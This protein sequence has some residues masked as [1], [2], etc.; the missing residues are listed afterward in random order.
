[1]L[2]GFLKDW[3]FWCSDILESHISY[4][5][6]G[7]FR[8][9]HTKQ[10][11]VSALACVLDLSSLIEV[12]IDGVP[13]WQAHVTF[14]MARHTAV[15]L[16]QVFRAPIADGDER[17]VDADFERMRNQLAAVGVCLADTPAAR[18]RL[19]T[20]RRS[21]EPYLVGLSRTL[22]MPLPPW[23]KERP[24]KDN[25]QSSPGGIEEAHF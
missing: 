25:W 23:W 10:S 18:D 7:F 22:L 24:E 11:W 21:Y 3:E 13:A 1:M 5:A 19:R 2:A 16:A 4:P 6:V 14:A 15:D 12:G 8:S 20:L 17:L 9:Q